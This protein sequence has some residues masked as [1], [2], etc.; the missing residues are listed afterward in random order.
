MRRRPS[1]CGGN[2]A[3]RLTP[4]ANAM[5][6]DLMRHDGELTGR[7]RIRSYRHIR[8]CREL[9]RS[10]PALQRLGVAFAIEPAVPR[11]RLIETERL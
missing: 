1:R 4:V 7:Q 11:V 5:L 2:R 9:R 3:A 8:I 6:R 10:N